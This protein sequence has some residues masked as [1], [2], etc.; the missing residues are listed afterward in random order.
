MIGKNE[1]LN[2][3]LK[4]LGYDLN[5]NSKMF[6]KI[7][8]G[9]EIKVDALNYKIDYGKDITYDRETCLNLAHQD[10]TQVTFEC[11]NRL[12]SLGYSPKKIVLEKSFPAGRNERGQ[13]LD[14]LVKN[15]DNNDTFMMI[16]CKTPKE[17]SIELSKMEFNGGQLFTYFSND[18]SSSYLSLYTSEYSNSDEKFIFYS[19]IINSKVLKGTTKEQIYENWNKT[20]E[21]NGVF[22]DGCLPYEIEFNGIRKNQLRKFTQYD[23]SVK[24]N[25][26]TIFNRFAEILRRNNISDKNN[27]YNKIFNLF[28]CKIVDEEERDQNDFMWFQWRE[29]ESAEDVLSRLSDLYKKGMEKYLKLEISDFT[30]SD[31]NKALNQDENNELIINMFRKL[32]LYKNNEFAFNEVINDRTFYE[33]AQVV[34]E[35]VKLLEIYQIKYSSKHQFLGDFFEKLLSIGVKQEAGQFFTP[36]PIANFIINSIPVESIIN[37]KINYG[38]DEYLPYIIDYAC[39]SGHFLTESMHRVD[40]CLK[41]SFKSLKTVPQ[42]NN[43]EKW[44]KDYSWTNEF[45]YGIELDYRLA[46]T[47]K[48]ACFLNGDGEANIFYA[49]GL[50]NFNSKNYYKRLKYNEGNENGKFDIVVANPPYSVKDFKTKLTHGEDYFTL[51]NCLA[52]KSDDI[53][54]LFVERTWQLLAEDGYCGIILPDTVLVNSSPKA[55]VDTRKFMLKNFI[56]KGI[57]H[58]GEQTFIKTGQTTVVLFMQ[59][60]R[61]SDVIFAENE[62]KKIIQKIRRC[63]EIQDVDFNN[64][65]TNNYGISLNEYIDYVKQFNL[66]DSEYDN[67]LIYK[68]NKDV[69]TVVSKT[70]KRTEEIEFLGYKHTD[71]R[72]YEGIKPYPDND[73]NKIISKLFN[74]DNINDSSKLSYYIYKNFINEQI[75]EEEIYRNSLEKNL[76][77][78]DLNDILSYPDELSEE[79][80]NDFMIITKDVPEIYYNSD[81]YYLEKIDKLYNNGISSG[82]NAPK[83]RYFVNNGNKNSCFIR[84]K[85]LNNKEGNFIRIQEDNFFELDDK[86]RNLF[87]SGTIV[88]PKSGQSVNTNNIAIIP[89][90][91]YIVNHLASLYTKNDILRDYTYY[92]LKHYKTSNLKLTDTGY[93]TIRIN[94]IKN[95]Q[96]PIPHKLELMKEIV[97]SLNAIERKNKTENK[98]MDEEA[99]IFRNK[100]LLYK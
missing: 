69:R 52:D 4:C 8:N 16:E 3:F 70:G 96:I 36:L 48:V 79:N 98:I 89:Q 56:I 54:L 67:F 72:N 58:L 40:K 18:R 34:K 83:P 6:V 38:E 37:K 25:E 88:F 46:K 11:I 22:E 86:N 99:E 29:C 13:Y 49:N 15:N 21:K 82:E 51:Y 80:I 75:D 41:N 39:G 50:D 94:T 97:D 64:Y 62:T 60:R 74:E 53:E 31:L 71:M 45:I 68:L 63:E 30:D 42:K 33:N 57:T 20:F 65:V 44:I 9:Y 19:N 47:T 28:L 24:G 10:E 7:I 85:H 78:A 12:I 77:L 35:V 59:K 32:R 81:I 76:Y 84:A 1:K 93:P 100:G 61:K 17:Y 66:Y 92:I 87:L 95:F 55:N 26:G 14:I 91:S 27:A 23:V 43:F 73:E 90:D 2:K 5:E